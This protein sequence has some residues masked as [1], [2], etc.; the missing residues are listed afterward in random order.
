MKNGHHALIL[1]AADVRALLPMRE[2]IDVMEKTFREFDPERTS[3]PNRTSMSAGRYDETML[4]MPAGIRPDAGA[5]WFGAKVLSIFPS[6]ATNARD[7]IQGLI[8]LFEGDYGSPVAIIDAAAVTAIRTAAVSAV[9]TKHLARRDASC[10]CLIGSGVQAL[11]H[12]TAMAVVRTIRAM[13][14]WSPDTDRCAALVR[15]AESEFGIPSTVAASARTAVEDADIICTVTTAGTP[16]VRSS[17][18]SDGAHVNAIGAHRPTA[19]ELDSDTVRRATLIVDHMPAAMVEAGDILIPITEGVITPSHVLGDL[20]DVLS[21]RIMG[22]ISAAEVTVFK[23]VGIAIEDIAAAAH[24]YSAAV[25][26][27]IGTSVR[28]S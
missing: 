3:V 4:V 2:C 15:V 16:V 10:L 21:G 11:S 18:I 25:A 26:R 6:N 17:W 5:G 27:D 13:R 20:S 28:L 22:R 1:S 8:V 19:R 9:A 24:V 12:L 23:S 14:V 7:A